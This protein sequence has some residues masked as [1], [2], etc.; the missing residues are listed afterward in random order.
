MALY[1]L[2]GGHSRWCYH[3]NGRLI[4][5]ETRATPVFSTTE[6]FG[7]H[8]ADGGLLYSP[9]WQRCVHDISLQVS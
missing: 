9:D 6:K 5:K 3:L 2:G 7:V 8:A 4:A 1:D